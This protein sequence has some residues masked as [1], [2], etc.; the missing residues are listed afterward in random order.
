MVDIRG[1]RN[2]FCAEGMLG[3]LLEMLPLGKSVKLALLWGVLR[4]REDD[5]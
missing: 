5:A 2:M 4:A 1:G 3:L